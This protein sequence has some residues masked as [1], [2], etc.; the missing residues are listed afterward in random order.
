MTEKESLANSTA[1][2]RDQ[3]AYFL[4]GAT[5]SLKVRKDN[6]RKLKR[7]LKENEDQIAEAL[8]KDYKK[9]YF[10]VI[11]NEL[12]LTYVEIGL[13]IRKLKRWSRPN[14]PAPSIVNI[15][16]NCRV[17]PQ[18]IGTALVISTWNYPVQLTLIPVVNALAAGN[19]VVLKP[20]EIS[21]H[22]SELL[23]ELINKTFP[24]EL[25]HTIYGGADVS[26]ELLDQKF[27]KIFFTGSTKVGRIVMRA[28]ARHLTPVTLEL[29]GKNPVIIMPDCNIKRTA[30][31]IV[32]GKFHNGG[33][34]CVSPDHFYVHESIE[35]ALLAE[36]QRN[37][38]KMFNGK[39]I[40][41]EALPRIVN[42]KHFRRLMKLIDQE[43]VLVGGQGKEDEL[44]IEPTVMTGVE[45]EDPVM[46]EEIFGPIMPFLRFSNLDQLLNTLK[47]KASPL[48]MYVFTGKLQLA[49]KIQREIR[50]GGGMINDTVVHFVN[51]STP[52]GGIGESGMGNYHGKA[53]FET[54][55][56]RKSVIKKPGWFELWV[57]YPPY[58]AFKLKIVRLLL[59]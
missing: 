7:M 10:E 22:T 58:T 50:A 23:T 35:N 29:G 44:F 33:Q 18:P 45:E 26:K 3:K 19:T 16:A 15:P 12:S 56:H 8:Y 28:A 31:R 54:F 4:S 42:Q 52:F 32:W 53:G 49:R 43:K 20:S 1:I 14:R 38:T 46:Q 5:Q 57:K 34:A 48:A 40:E 24:K 21:H 13:A 41:S 30:Q 36:V 6:L 11:E 55:S 25:L 59:R 9:S 37:I 51:A 39:A 17:Y 2:I 47:Q 27:D